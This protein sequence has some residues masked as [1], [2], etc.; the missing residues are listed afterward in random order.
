MK[1]K[2][3]KPLVMIG[4]LAVGLAAGHYTNQ[5]NFMAANPLVGNAVKFGL[6]VIGAVSTKGFAQSVAYGIGAHG[7]YGGA[8]TVMPSI[9][10]LPPVG[11][12]SV[13]MVAGPGAYEYGPTM[14]VD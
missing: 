4:G 13:H 9:G 2:Y 10:Y 6:G 8:K 12:T 1:K 7:L 14:I 5:L 11:S 3:Q